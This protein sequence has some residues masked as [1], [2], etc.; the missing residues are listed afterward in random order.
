MT[1]PSVNRRRFVANA[2]MI[3]LALLVF[4]MPATQNVFACA[5]NE[6][7]EITERALHFPCTLFDHGKCFTLDRFDPTCPQCL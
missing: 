5:L 3:V 4:A 6:F 7:S 1:H 2:A